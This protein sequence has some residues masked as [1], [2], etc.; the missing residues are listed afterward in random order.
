MARVFGFPRASRGRAQGMTIAPPAPARPQGGLRP[1]PL[2][3]VRSMAL[4]AERT[5]TA[6]MVQ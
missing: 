6:G 1:A 4:A 2:D 5:A 3:G